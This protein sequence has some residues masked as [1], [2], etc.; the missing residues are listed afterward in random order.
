MLQLELL[1][2]EHK[3]HLLINQ[4]RAFNHGVKFVS[5]AF[6]LCQAKNN[7]AIK[8]PSVLTPEYFLTLTVNRLKHAS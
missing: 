3:A 6:N 5:K 4:R 7:G 2:D 1:S 8:K